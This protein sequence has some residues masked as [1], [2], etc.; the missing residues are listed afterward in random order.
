MRPFCGIFLVDWG[1][2]K[3]NW[4]EG[5]FIKFVCG[6]RKKRGEERDCPPNYLNTL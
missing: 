4:M 3:E 1:K 2:M 6:V 5:M